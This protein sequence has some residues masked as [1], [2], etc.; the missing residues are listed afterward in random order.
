MK[1]IFTSQKRYT[2]LTGLLCERLGFVPLSTFRRQ[3][4]AGEIRVNGVKTL[5]DIP[6]NFGDEVKLFLPDKLVPPVFMPEFVYADDNLAVAVKPVLCDT[7]THLTSAVRTRFPSAVP[8]HRLDFNTRGLVMFALTMTAEQE[9]LR[10]IKQRK[11]EKS[12]RA[13]VYGHMQKSADTVTVYLKKDAEAGRVFVSDVPKTGYLTAETSYTVIGYEGEDTRLD[14]I[15]HTGRT[16]Q[17]RATFAHLGHPV[18]GD[19]KYGIESVNRA[20]NAKFQCLTAYKIRFGGLT[21]EDKNLLA[22]LRDLEIC[23]PERE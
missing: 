1:H 15:L 17:I 13:L 9:L 20:R 10:L 3:L 6:L 11:I 8:V 2:K 21:I 7:E 16:H 5:T 19:G 22:Y 23:L 12:Y 4:K 18:I 14:I